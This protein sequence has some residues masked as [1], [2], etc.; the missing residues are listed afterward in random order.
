MKIELE[1]NK[2]DIL[3]IVKRYYEGYKKDLNTFNLSDLLEAQLIDEYFEI[4]GT[5]KLLNKEEIIDIIKK[6]I[7]IEN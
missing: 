7:N 6:E 1:I 5:F 2:G 3:E 4:V